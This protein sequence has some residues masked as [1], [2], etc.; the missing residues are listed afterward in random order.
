MPRPSAVPPTPLVPPRPPGRPRSEHLCRAIRTAALDLLVKHGFSD[1]TIEAISARAK[2]GKATVYRRWPC[3]ADLI[4]DAFFETVSP[5][6]RFGDSGSLREDLRTQLRLVVRE[7]MG[8]HGRVLATLLA[9]MQLDEHLKEAFR[10]RWLELRRAEG[11]TAIQRGIDRGEIA[12]SIE[13]D[14]V[15]DALYSPL[16]FRLMVG[17]QPLSVGY[18]DQLV[19]LVF[20]GL[21]GIESTRSSARSRARPRSRSTK[22]RKGASH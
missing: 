18:G 12:A 5:R 21:A 15:L 1:L 17:H 4:V 10:T 14:F 3:K 8:P 2:V 7:M 11:R 16:Y 22:A 20:D 19:D 13:P 6:V 9:C